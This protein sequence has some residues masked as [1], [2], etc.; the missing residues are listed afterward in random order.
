MPL[1]VC[2]RWK[3]MAKAREGQTLAWVLPERLADYAMPAADLPL[4]P[5]L[6]E[7]L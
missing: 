1:Y 7:L 4:V 3:G 2:R 5:L 6:R